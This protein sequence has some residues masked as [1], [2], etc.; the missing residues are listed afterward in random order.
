MSQAKGVLISLIVIF[1]PTSTT[2]QNAQGIHQVKTL[3]RQ[4]MDRSLPFQS[5]ILRGEEALPIAEGAQLDSLLGLLHTQLGVLYWEDGQFPKAV[6]HLAKGQAISLSRGDSLQWARN[7]H[8]KG[9]V[10]YYRCL[11]DS[12]LILYDEVDQVYVRHHCDSAVAKVKSHKGLIYSA[13]GKYQLAIQNMIASFKLQESQP[14]Y[15]DVSIR[16]EFSSNEAEKLF[17]NG[18]LE[19]D[20]ESLRFI[21]KGTDQK[22]LAF[23]FHNIGLDFLYLQRYQDA[24]QYFKRSTKVYQKMNH[25]SLSGD[26]ARAYE[27]IGLY[28]SAIFYHNKWIDETKSRG[29]QIHLIAAYSNLAKYYQLQKKWKAALDYYSLAASLNRK[30]GLRRSESYDL[31]S[32][33]LILAQLG[34]WRKAL[35]EIDL[36]LLIAREIGC[37]RDTQEILEV[38]AGILK[39]LGRDREAV[40][41]LSTS[42]VVRNSIVAGENALQVA[43]LQIEYETE[44]KSRELLKLQS[45]NLLSEKKIESRN[46]WIALSASLLAL[47]TSVGMFYYLRYSQKKKSEAMITEQKNVIELQNEGLQKKNRENEIL[48]AEIHHRVKNN[49]QIISSLINLRI[50]KEGDMTKGFLIDLA[51][52]VYVMGLVHDML[53]QQDQLEKINMKEYL[54]ELTKKISSSL[55]DYE[56]NI[57]FVFSGCSIQLS[58]DKAL[59]LGL[60]HN[61]LV[62]NAI[63]YA[64]PASHLIITS[65]LR[66]NESKTHYIYYLKDNGNNIKKTE[67]AFGLRFV[68]QVVKQKLNGKFHILTGEGYSTE[69]HFSI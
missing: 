9:L 46:L 29:S 14:A 35:E 39:S 34:Q 63:K 22:K 1:W 18:K 69:V 64:M 44:K 67:P 48:L 20:L 40:E 52:K 53:Y 57:E 10:Y 21:E 17:Y 66:I 12:A 8:Y 25:V 28:D 13:E 51:N 6:D 42:L 59:S 37:I 47:L 2:G 33:A 16:M 36:S 32:I 45:Q 41:A 55:I 49:L 24:L 56:R 7:T 23:T 43:R 5:M 30:I 15:R 19:K 50:G 54:E 3:Y 26:L 11:F 38:K 68:D 31:K 27:G 62:T 4:S 58:L 60:V 65:G 61:E